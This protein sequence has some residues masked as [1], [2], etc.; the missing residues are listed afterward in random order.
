VGELADGQVKAVS[1][2]VIILDSLG[3]PFSPWSGGAQRYCYEIGRRLVLEGFEVTWLSNGFQGAARD[4]VVAGIRF[5]RHG[6]QYTSYIRSC[7]KLSSSHRDALIFESI[8][9]IPFFTPILARHR[10]LSMIHHIVPFA[11]LARKVGTFA[12]FVAGVQNVLSPLLYRKRPIITNSRSTFDELRGQGYLD[13][14]IVRLGVELPD[15]AMVAFDAKEKS[16]VMVGPLRPWKRIGHGLM[17]FASL[18]KEWSLNVIGSF[19]SDE[20]R[21]ELTYLADRLGIRGRTNFTGRI[22]E[23]EKNEIYRKAS[24]AIVTSEKE[25]WGLAAAEPQA[26]GCPVVGYDVPGIRD[27]VHNGKT[28]ILVRSGDVV[29]L[30]AALTHVTEDPSRLR[31]LATNA[32]SLY[33]GY[34]WDEVFRDF[35]QIFTSQFRL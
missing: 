29:A 19:E 4:E 30:S 20:Y 24:V 13:V 34:S 14:Q 12:P 11:T 10:T 6:S 25:G 17:A 22:S 18:P 5:I 8:S 35:F 15:P 31:C 33:R 9:A 23:G 26:Y 1:N 2:E 16:V 7:L 32:H 27:S 28:G 21:E 3:D